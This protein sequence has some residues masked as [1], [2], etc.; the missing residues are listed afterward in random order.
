VDGMIPGSGAEPLNL[1]EINDRIHLVTEAIEDSEKM[2][3]L[4]AGQPVIFNLAGEI[5]HIRSVEDPMRDLKINTV[6]H[7]QFLNQCRLENP[8][9]TI[10]YASSRQVY[11]NAQYLP[12]DEKHSVSP[13]DFN[14]V[15]KLATEHYH[16]LLRNQFEMR[17]ICLRL[18]N[19]YGPRQAI[20]VNCRGFIDVFIRL[21]LSGKQLSVFGDGEQL[22]T[23]LY[24]D[25]A[26][27]AFLL[28]GQAGPDAAQIYNVAGFEPTSLFDIA[29]IL[30]RVAALDTPRLVPFPPE[31]KAIDIGSFYSSN[32]KFRNAF[33]WQ[34]KIGLAEGFHQTLE[35]FSTERKDWLD[36][37]G[38]TRARPVGA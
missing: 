24:V 36:A 28:A 17:T 30:S 4:I 7:L 21:A 29:Q 2:R 33:G 9:A 14:G 15:H 10:V 34:P 25:D 19:I 3:S 11:G 23:M 20:H 1:E 32:E 37:M 8:G 16:Q 18:G 6:A 35:F 5:S 26:V 12:V 27:D 38:I 31:R 22:R 13:V